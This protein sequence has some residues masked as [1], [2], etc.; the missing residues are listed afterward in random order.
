MGKAVIVHG[1]KN[2]CA[3]QDARAVVST[4][5]IEKIFVGQRDGDPIF[6]LPG[7]IVDLIRNRIRSSVDRDRV[8]RDRQS[9]LRTVTCCQKEQ[10]TKNKEKRF[11][12]HT[13]MVL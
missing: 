10:G 7:L 12:F 4:D 8:R 2:R 5:G 1:G 13:Y 3:A 11:R 6:A 9:S